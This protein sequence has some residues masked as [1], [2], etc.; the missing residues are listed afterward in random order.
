MFSIPNVYT[1]IHIIYLRDILKYTVSLLL[2]LLRSRIIVTP[3]GFKFT[4]FWKSIRTVDCA[5]AGSGESL[6]FFNQTSAERNRPSKY[7][8][9]IILLC[10]YTPR[11]RQ[12]V[13]RLMGSPSI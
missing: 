11:I 7:T 2:L 9:Y 5:R 6:F 8:V 1:I 4:R 12:N 10:V 13:F 3:D